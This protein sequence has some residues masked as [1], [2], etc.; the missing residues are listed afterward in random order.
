MYAQWP[1][2]LRLRLPLPS[3][4]SGWQAGT[5]HWRV[6]KSP[7]G[8]SRPFQSHRRPV[9]RRARRRSWASA[10]T[11]TRARPV[12]RSKAWSQAGVAGGNLRGHGAICSSRSSRSSTPASTLFTSPCD[13]ET[14]TLM[15]YV[16]RSLH[17]LPNLWLI[18]LTQCKFGS[19]KSYF[20]NVVYRK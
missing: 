9:N 8:H 6:P 13:R 1:L 12:S 19:I 7:S 17:C 16:Q 20:T 11:A 2:R 18:I 3:S 10:A 5:S 4:P 14:G 15:K